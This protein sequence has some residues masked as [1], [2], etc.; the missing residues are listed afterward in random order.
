VTDP[1]REN[2]LLLS[3]ARADAALRDLEFEQQQLPKRIAVVERALAKI[4][5]DEAAALARLEAVRK[6]RRTLEQALQD[7]EEQLKKYKAQLMQVGSNK[8]YTAML[9]EIGA[10]E[11]KIDEEEERLLLLMDEVETAE[12]SND[13][14]VAGFREQRDTRTA[15]KQTIEARVEEVTA[16]VARLRQEKPKLLGELEPATRKRY[17]RL[18][19]RHGD[20]GVVRLSGGHCGGCGTQIPPQVDVEVRKANQIITCQS[21]GR[22]LVDDPA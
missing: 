11:K 15:E 19:Q 12:T 20:T 13:E 2:F 10:V 6:E 8:E 21:C 4:D 7:H 22:I 1:Q 3:I 14:T 16:E 5:A 9:H 17:E 18:L